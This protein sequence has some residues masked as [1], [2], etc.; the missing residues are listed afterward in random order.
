ML[1]CIILFALTFDFAVDKLPLLMKL[2][3]L[4]L[5]CDPPS[6]SSCCRMDEVHFKL[7][8]HGEINI[9]SIYRFFRSLLSSPLLSKMIILEHMYIHAPTQYTI[10]YLQSITL[11]KLP[12][13]RV[14]KV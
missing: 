8:Y 14:N 5:A 12:Y 2:L 11:L 3:C 9:C 1:L 4:T 7:L 6:S 10:H 13:I